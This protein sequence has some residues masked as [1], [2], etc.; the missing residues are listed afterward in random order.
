M[1]PSTIRTR[2]RA[3]CR[4]SPATSRSQARGPA[5]RCS[6]ARRAMPSA[7]S[8]PSPA[9]SCCVVSPPRDS[10][11][12]R[13][14]LDSGRPLT[15]RRVAP[16]TPSPLPSAWRTSSC[17][18]CAA[19]TERSRSSSRRR[20]SGGRASSTRAQ[21]PPRAECADRGVACTSPTAASMP[22]IASLR[23]AP[24]SP[25]AGWSCCSPRRAAS[26][27]VRSRATPAPTAARST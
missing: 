22:R 19:A 17:A 12:R 11:R 20:S 7:W 6:G 16:S 26:P 8:S 14:R 5:R 9:G 15:S 2:A 1:V 13:H 4:T 23:T 25:A 24:A 3:R 27:A 10:N 18:T 21:E